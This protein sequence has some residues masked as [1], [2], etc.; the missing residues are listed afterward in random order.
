MKFSVGKAGAASVMVDSRSEVQ[1]GPGEEGV[2]DRGDSLGG[3][4]AKVIWGTGKG[5]RGE[6]VL[7]SGGWPEA[8]GVRDEPRVSS[9]LAAEVRKWPWGARG[10]HLHLLPLRGEPQLLLGRQGG[11]ALSRGSSRGLPGGR[12]GKRRA[13]WEG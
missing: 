6:G 13:H 2:Q 9:V 1:E 11:L 5:W 7:G 12:G 3:D 10:C 8:V 4:G